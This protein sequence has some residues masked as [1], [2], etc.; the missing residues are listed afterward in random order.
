MKLFR[1]LFLFLFIFPFT[2]LSQGGSNYSVFGLGDIFSSSNAAYDGLAGTSA[3][4]ARESYINMRNPALWSKVTT[5]R[6]Q[7]GYRFNQ[8]ISNVKENYLYQNNGK[9][10]DIIGL[11]SVD[12]SSGF[13]VGFGIFPFSSVNYLVRSPV[14]VQTEDLALD[15]TVEF[16]GNGGLT[17]VFLGASVNLMKNLAL[18]IAGFG[19]FGLISSRVST[20]FNLQNSYPAYSE[21]DD[22]LSGFGI[23]SGLYYTINENFNAG[24][25][26]EH[27]FDITVNRKNLYWSQIFKGLAIYDT[28][29]IKVPPAFGAGL[30][31]QT[32]RFLMGMDVSMQDFT[33]FNYQKGPNNS[34]RNNI[35]LSAGLSRTGNPAFAADIT[36]RITYNLGFCYKQLYYKVAGSGIDEY[37]GAF[38]VNVPLAGSAIIDAA[39]NIGKRGTSQNNLINEY[40]GRIMIDVS[41]G[42]TWFKPFKREY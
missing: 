5:T 25:F 12:T 26:Y 24:L 28:T 27:Y 32:G 9:L 21:K 20:Q 16:H 18:G 2:A 38:G 35:R 1:Y 42:E 22:E 30:S 19:N 14:H 15:G 8:H 36:D 34:F 7:A 31:Y 13:S 33:D 37:F 4:I 23:R 40:F 41:I 6:L 10:N 3:A 29:T 11:F 17:Q 39:I